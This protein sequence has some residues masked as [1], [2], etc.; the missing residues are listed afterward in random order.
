MLKDTRSIIIETLVNINFL[1]M[2]DRSMVHTQEQTTHFI[3]T[4]TDNYTVLENILE[5]KLIPTYYFDRIYYSGQ[6]LVPH[7]DWEGCEV[8]VTLQIETTLKSAWDFYVEGT[9]I[10]M[11]DG[12]AVIYNGMFAK[13]WRKPMEGNSKDYHHQIFYITSYIIVLAI[14]LC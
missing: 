3:K 11:E 9:P 12:D 1:M 5:T 6:E 4:Y 2:R 10:K 14:L 8:S 7:T 13:H